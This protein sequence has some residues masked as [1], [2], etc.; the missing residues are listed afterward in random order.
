MSGCGAPDQSAVPAGAPVAEAAGSVIVGEVRS[1]SGEPVGGTFVRLLDPGG[2]FVAEVVSA[3]TGAFRFFTVPGTWT[4]R[5]VSAGGNGE[6]T[7]SV[8][9]GDTP[10]RLILAG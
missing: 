9:H 8:G 10:V 3:P 7:V 2:D 4:V 5:A 6:T 1:A